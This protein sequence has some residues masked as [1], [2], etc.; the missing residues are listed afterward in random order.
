MQ[1]IVSKLNEC[2]FGICI[3]HPFVII[4]FALLGIFT[5]SVNPIIG[6]FIISLECIL[7]SFNIVFTIKKIKFGHL[8]AKIIKWRLTK[9]E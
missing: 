9:I 2:N 3:I 7:F 8:I 1:P 5:Y 6:I 4:T